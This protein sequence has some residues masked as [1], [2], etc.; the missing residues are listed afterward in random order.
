MCQ[1]YAYCGYT[2]KHYHCFRE[3]NKTIPT[4]AYVFTRNSNLQTAE[5]NKTHST[6]QCLLISSILLVHEKFARRTVGKQQKRR[7]IL[8]IPSSRCKQIIYIISTSWKYTFFAAL[9]TFNPNWRAS[10]LFDFDFLLLARERQKTNQTKVEAY[11][12]GLII[13]RAT[14]NVFSKYWN[15]PYLFSYLT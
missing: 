12:F 11:Q 8:L 1:L 3:I 9:S 14:K 5:N 13:E 4:H 15:Y 7:F 2:H 10:I 6:D